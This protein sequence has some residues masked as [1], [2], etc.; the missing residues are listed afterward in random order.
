MR[1]LASRTA[2]A[3]AGAAVLAVVAAG[4]LMHLGY[5]AMPV[6]SG[7]MEPGIAT[8][9]VVIIKQVPTASI[10]KGDV[11][12]FERPDAKASR[13]THR[14]VAVRE[15]EGRRVFRTKGDANTTL[16]PWAL[17]LP[18][19]VHRY[20]AD[21]PRVGRILLFAARPEIRAAATALLFLTVLIAL[22]NAIW[23][24]RPQRL[25]T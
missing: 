7:S 14:V 16:D 6:L 2:S 12:T 10:N 18:A 25:S 20:V 8:G 3:L 1:R 19:E 21:L 9:G 17:A 4:V 24:P 23:R 11:I 15:R 22:L 13:V 5:R